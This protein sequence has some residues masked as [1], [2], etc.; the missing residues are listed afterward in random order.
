MA[1][2]G[3]W[4]MRYETL[5][6]TPGLGTLFENILISLQH[7]LHL[8]GIQQGRGGRREGEDNE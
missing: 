6:Y 3:F 7:F 4:N 8:Q 5:V 1:R 2:M